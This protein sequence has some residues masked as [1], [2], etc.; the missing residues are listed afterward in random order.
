MHGKCAYEAYQEKARDLVRAARRSRVYHDVDSL[1]G[2]QP[3]LRKDGGGFDGMRVSTSRKRVRRQA[4]TE[5]T[6]LVT[7][8]DDW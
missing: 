1:E 6:S 3:A 5:Q 8:G 4:V 2:V 7:T